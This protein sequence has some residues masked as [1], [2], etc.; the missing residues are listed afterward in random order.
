MYTSTSNTPL[1]AG[2]KPSV[3][4]DVTADV[5]RF[6]PVTIDMQTHI[7]ESSITD[8]TLRK[9]NIGAGIL[10]SIQGALLLVASQTVPQ[11]KDKVTNPITTGFLFY[12][13][14]SKHLEPRTQSVGHF[15]IALMAAVFLLMSAVAHAVVIIKWDTYIADIRKGKNRF[16][17]F[18]YAVSSSLMICG[19]A[20]CFGAY[21]L[22]TQILMFFC[23]ACMNLFG[24]LMEDMNPPDT[25]KVDW[26]PFIYGCV[27][28]VA[29]WI[30]VLMYFLGGGN[31]SQIPGFVYAIL[32]V[33]FFFFNTFPVNM[34]LQYAKYGKW[35]D[36]RHGEKVYIVLSLVSKS[37]LGWLVFG[38]AFQP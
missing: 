11:I 12:N 27:A 5:N 20:W 10:H 1:L 33:Y 32:F 30:V 23:N 19:I 21:D 35:K 16:R 26:S 37:M 4:T 14:T 36:Y 9:F 31:F 24:R 28:G 18:E 13:Q 22:G 2:N 6:T 38:A 17:W 15:E 29:P 3:T 8:Q 7:V 25:V 34:A